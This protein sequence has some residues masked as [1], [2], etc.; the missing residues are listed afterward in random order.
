[1]DASVLN[2][3]AY[4]EQQYPHALEAQYPRILDKIVALW[5][6]PSMGAYFAS[7]Q[8]DER[9][10][11]QGFPE[12]VRHDIDMIYQRYQKHAQVS[13]FN[14]WGHVSQALK[15]EIRRNRV[16]YAPKGFFKACT[17]GMERVVALFLNIGWPT[18]LR[19]SRGWTPIM[20]AAL[21]GHV[22]VVNM[23]LKSGADVA[24]RNQNGC[25][26]LHWAAFSGRSKVAHILISNGADVNARSDYGWTPLLQ[27]AA[28]G[29][30]LT[31]SM[32]LENGADLRL[33]SRTGMTPLHKA[34]V[35]GNVAELVLL[36]SKGADPHVLDNEGLT[37][38]D[39]ARAGGFELAVGRLQQFG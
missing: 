3:I 36:L 33:A 28:K 18:E 25:T 14:P 27:A 31:S 17:Q 2:I 8:I 7:L 1:M 9:G 5:D 26:A 10:G 37:A 38:L 23:L 30:L 21:N 20:F 22:D 29:Y 35:S 11:R 39:Y 32:L 13:D 15:K 34:A 16:S 24:A 19:D 12:A 6:K 4:D